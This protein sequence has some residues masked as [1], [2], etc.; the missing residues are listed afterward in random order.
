[1]AI[2]NEIWI[3]GRFRPA[4]EA[5]VPVLDRGLLFAHAAY[6]VMA[7]YAGRM[8][9]WPAHL[10]R[11]Q[12]SLAGLDLALPLDGAELETVLGELI[13]RNDCREGVV[14]LQVTA[15]AGP[16]RDFAG[17]DAFKPRLIAFT[18][19][20]PLIGPPARDG[21]AAV[22]VEETRWAR[23][24]LKTTQLL[25]QALAYRAARRAGAWTAWMVEDGYV[26]EAASANAWIVAESGTL[27]TRQ[28]SNA[29]L[30]G[31]TRAALLSLLA[32]GGVRVE[33]R[34]FTVAEA[35]SAREAL[36]SS[37]GALILPVTQI[38]GEAIDTGTPGPVTRRL[39]ALYY[40]HI[41]ADLAK[42]AP[43]AG[44]VD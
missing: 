39:Q 16:G 21:V 22:T 19:S 1:M 13:T 10:Q 37:S 41:G 40:R 6:E 42:V 43:W 30:A 8:V 34:L 23:R 2:G 28:L 15:G 32:A 11:L 26:T 36:T 7:V 35:L 38:D 9:D 31:I 24:D 25:S 3:D 18:D 20:R 27:V 12:Q 33:E 17:P 44:E 14:Y 29:I 5:Q 4:A